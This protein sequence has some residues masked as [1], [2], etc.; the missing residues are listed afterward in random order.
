[1]PKLGR[2]KILMHT[3]FSSSEIVNEIA[4][5]NQENEE[6][7]SKEFLFCLPSHSHYGVET[8]L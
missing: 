7:S 2:T 1:M 8:I 3:S 5:E 6:V 4:A